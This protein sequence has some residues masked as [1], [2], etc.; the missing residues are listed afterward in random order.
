MP[1]IEN[2]LIPGSTELPDCKC[3]AELQLFRVKQLE[4]TE[5]RVF[6]CDA[7]QHELQLMVWRELRQS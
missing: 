7:C 1:A 5:I 4:D 2:L 3:G 6:K